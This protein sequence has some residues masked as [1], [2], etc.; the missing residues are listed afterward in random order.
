MAPVGILSADESKTEGYPSLCRRLYELGL[1][2]FTL[3]IVVS[4]G[5]CT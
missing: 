1:I 2:A 5:I 4:R 3:M